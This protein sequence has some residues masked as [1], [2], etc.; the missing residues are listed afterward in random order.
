MGSDD[1]ALNCTDRLRILDRVVAA[2]LYN[3]QE[4]D[5][6]EGTGFLLT[7]FQALVVEVS[8]F[9]KGF[10]EGAVDRLTS[11]DELPDYDNY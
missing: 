6:I 2:L 7:D 11:K 10:V 1:K 9:R 3:A 5:Q 8:R 4:L